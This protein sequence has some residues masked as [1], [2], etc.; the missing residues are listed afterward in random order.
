[1]EFDFGKSTKVASLDSVPEQ[2]RAL[3]KEVEGEGFVLDSEDPKVAGAVSAIA[4]LNKA[5]RA[6]RA[7]ARSKTPI[8]LSPLSEY[9]ADPEEIAEAIRA[10]LDEAAKAKGPGIDLEKI[11]ADLARTHAGELEKERK[12]AEA[13]QGQLYKVLVENAARQEIATQ[14]GDADLLM[15]FVKER[16]TVS[17]DGGEFRVHVVDGT[18]DARYSGV[19]GSPMTLRELVA[20]MKADKRYGRLFESD[21]PDGGGTP[22]SG[23]KRPLG[24]ETADLSPVEKIK[25]GLQEGKYRRESR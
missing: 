3:Y 18:G 10:K 9:G 1:M 23:P 25:K 5:L 21:A 22:P 11:K 20:E 17:E 6:A 13:L 19:T 14:K 2:F 4:G 15:P 16:V 7:D 24:R 8:D 12:R